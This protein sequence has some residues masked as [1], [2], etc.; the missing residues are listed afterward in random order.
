MAMK[1]YN[2]KAYN[3]LLHQ[4]RETELFLSA[5][6]LN[7]FSLLE[8]WETP[9]T[10]SQGTGWSARSLVFFLN[11]LA[12]IGLIEK[13]RNTYRNTPESNK[14]LN[15]S[16]TVYLGES[17]LFREKMMSLDRLDERVKNGP[18]SSVLQN[19]KGVE[20]YDFYEAA[21]VSVPE[22]YAGRVQALVRDITLLFGDMAPKKILDLGGGSGILA[23]ETVSAFSSCR[24]VVF[25]HP[26]VANL[27]RSIISER[28]FSERIDVM[29]G[30]FNT[31]DIGCG[32]DL[33]I[34]SGI[35]D[36]AKDHLDSLMEKL[37]RA[38]MPGGC[39]YVITHNVGEDYQTPPESILG[40]LSG[41]LDG[42]DVLLT[43]KTIEDALKRHGFTRV[44]VG[45]G[46]ETME[47]FQG[48][49]YRIDKGDV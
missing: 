42:L 4:K 41:H 25:E 44:Y 39:L 16:S 46:S 8:D 11:A 26:G 17:I 18:V 3:G 31:D 2:P 1:K 35:L 43:G 14:Y 28:G 27:P 10:V 49:F 23:L 32:Y 40:W 29:E 30:D 24:G 38:L 20:V 12:S 33:I 15:K 47:G 36:F 5:L 19:N 22:M 6:R 21:R 9:E 7:L 34:A 37:K 48:E 45:D 13:N